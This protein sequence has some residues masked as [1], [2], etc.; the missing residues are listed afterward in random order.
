MS[1]YEKR[2]NRIIEL[3]EKYK[4]KLSEIACEMEKN[5]LQE[6]IEHIGKVSNIIKLLTGIMDNP[7]DLDDFNFY[8]KIFAA[9]RIMNMVNDNVKENIRKSIEEYYENEDEK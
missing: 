8:C 3:M 4:E 2:L 7:Y 5:A 1:D 9:S 6:N